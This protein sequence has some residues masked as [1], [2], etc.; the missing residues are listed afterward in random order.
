MRKQSYISALTSESRGK[1]SEWVIHSHCARYGECGFIFLGAERENEIEADAC[2][3]S[4][5]IDMR[6]TRSASLG[7]HSLA[8]WPAGAGKGNIWAWPG[9]GLA[10]ETAF[11]SA[12]VRSHEGRRNK[13]D[14]RRLRCP[15]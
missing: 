5:G 2:C 13:E 1:E 9:W 4:E 10:S 6:N 14:Q 7:S 12:A 15:Q 8:T 11:K 3:E